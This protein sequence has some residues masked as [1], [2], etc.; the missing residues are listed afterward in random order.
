MIYLYAWL[1]VGAVVLVVMLGIQRWDERKSAHPSQAAP[2]VR[3]PWRE[4]WVEDGLARALAMLLVIVVWPLG[5]YMKLEDSLRTSRNNQDQRFAVLRSH[6]QARLSVAEIERRERVTDPHHAA[7][8]LPFGHLY[9]A[10]QEL[11]AHRPE[12]SE[13]W[14]F[15]AQWKTSFGLKERREGYVVVDQG[16]PGAYLMTVLRALED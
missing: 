5:L 8:D 9:P 10:W 11:L 15:S 14:L 4:R 2:R 3:K 6:L 16:V 12:G 13:L 1:A 7:P